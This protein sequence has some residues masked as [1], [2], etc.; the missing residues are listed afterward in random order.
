MEDKLRM[1][2]FWLFGTFVILFAAI[3]AYFGYIAG[4]AIFKNLYY[5]IFIVV[6]AV[7]C[8]AGF[9]IYKSYLG[10]KE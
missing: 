10:K 4:L 1:M 8:V 2:R 5:W 9:Y 7:L 3:T 6:A